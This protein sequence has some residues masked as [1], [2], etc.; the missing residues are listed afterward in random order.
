MTEGFQI[1]DD[2]YEDLIAKDVD[3]ILNDLAAGKR[4]KPGP[5]SGRL[6]AEPLGGL[7]SLTEDPPKPGFGLQPGL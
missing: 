2:F 1:N 7:T 5:R 3:D 6:A 4:P